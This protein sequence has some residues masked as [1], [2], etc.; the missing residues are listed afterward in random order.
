[1]QA[2]HNPFWKGKNENEKKNRSIK[3]DDK[4]CGTESGC[5][6]LSVLSVCDKKKWI[7]QCFGE[8]LQL[9]CIHT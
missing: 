7:L 3:H 1:M 8:G 9:N 2:Y 6:P 4:N 5:Q